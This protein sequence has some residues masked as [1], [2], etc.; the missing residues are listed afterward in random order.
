MSTLDNLLRWFKLLQLQLVN[1]NYLQFCKFYICATIKLKLIF[2]PLNSAYL[3]WEIIY[4][5]KRRVCLGVCVYVYVRDVV[6]FFP[7][8]HS[9]TKNNNQKINILLFGK[10]YFVLKNIESDYVFLNCRKCCVI[11]KQRLK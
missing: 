6:K 3:R 4:I 2:P 10:K 8:A 11:N 9:L 1:I 5:T 7:S